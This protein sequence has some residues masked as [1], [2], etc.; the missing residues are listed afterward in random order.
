M[1]IS[2]G[3]EKTPV[4]RLTPVLPYRVQ[5]LGFLKHPGLEFSESFWDPLP[6]GFN[7]YDDGPDDSLLKPIAGDL[8]QTDDPK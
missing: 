1:I 4:V 6:R 2:S 5:R 7:G 3:R 8:T